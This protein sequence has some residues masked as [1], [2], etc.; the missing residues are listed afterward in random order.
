MIKPARRN[1]YPQILEIER[2][3]NIV[4][5]DDFQNEAL[6]SSAWENQDVF[7]L[8]I[9]DKEA[10]AIICTSIENPDKIHGFCIHY[11][12]KKKGR[13]EILKLEGDNAACYEMFHHVEQM[14]HK[15]N[16]KQIII[17]S[18]E[19]RTAQHFT[20]Q[21]LGGI[22]IKTIRNRYEDGSAGYVFSWDVK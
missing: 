9:A 20:L 1:H 7:D 3:N 10:V 15:Y 6:L 14:C 12:N 22:A 11:Y 5:D 19:A 18:H 2:R 16:Y 8:E 17:V 4:M 13:V 21:N